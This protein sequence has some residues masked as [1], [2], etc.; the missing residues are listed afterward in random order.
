MTLLLSIAVAAVCSFSLAPPMVTSPT[1]RPSIG[2]RMW[3]DQE[4]HHSGHDPDYVDHIE[5]K[6]ALLCNE[7]GERFPEQC[8]ANGCLS[9][10]AYVQTLE[11]TAA[12]HKAIALVERYGRRDGHQ[13]HQH[14]EVSYDQQ[15]GGYDQGGYG[16][17]QGGYGQQQGDYGQ[18]QGDYGQQ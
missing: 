13:R 10:D 15:L 5:Q 6:V 18:Q 7:A 2:V 1:Q 3:H 17:Q 11:A 12:T 14:E 16:Q 8:D 4:A 9:F